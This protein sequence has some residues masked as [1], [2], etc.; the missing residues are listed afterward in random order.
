MILLFNEVKIVYSRKGIWNIFVENEKLLA[1]NVLCVGISNRLHLFI[2]SVS[3]DCLQVTSLMVLSVCCLFFYLETVHKE[4]FCFVQ[5][6]ASRT[7]WMP[8]CVLVNFFQVLLELHCNTAMFFWSVIYND[9]H[10]SI[11][12]FEHIIFWIVLSAF[13]LS[14]LLFIHLLATCLL[15]SIIYCWKHSITDFSKVHREQLGR[16][17]CFTELTTIKKNYD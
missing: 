8:Q 11:R 9:L 1:Q 15:Y 14:P 12:C 7:Q 4:I 10:I 3:T 13:W 2:N 5:G 17:Y 6:S 16:N